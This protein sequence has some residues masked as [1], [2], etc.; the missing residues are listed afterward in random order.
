MENIR[1]E[2]PYSI[3]Y[4]YTVTDKADGQ[5]MLL[6][7][8]NTGETWMNKLHL[9]DS[10]LKILPVDI[11]VK[12]N[13]GLYIFNGE[14]ITSLDRNKYGIFDTYFIN[15]Q[16]YIHAPLLLDDDDNTRI[17]KAIDFI[18]NN[19]ENNDNSMEIMVKRFI[20]GNDNMDIWTAGR[21]IWNNK[22]TYH[23]DGLIY[24]PAYEP[25]GFDINNKDSD[26]RL[27]T[28]WTRNMKWKPEYENTIDCLIR[29]EKDIKARYNGREVLVDKIENKAELTSGGQHEIKQYKIGNIF[30]GGNNEIYTTRDGKKIYS[31]LKPLPFKPR[32]NNDIV[33]NKIYLPLI[34]DTHNG[35]WRIL[36]KDNKEVEDDTIVELIYDKTNEEERYQY[37]WSILRT[38]YDKTYLYK[39]GRYAQ[40]YL[41]NILQICLKADRP[42]ESM[43]TKLLKYIY[44]PDDKD[45]NIVNRFI[46]N[47]KYIMATYKS[48][49][50]IKVD[51]KFG[52]TMKVA[53]SI[54]NSIHNPITEKNILYGEDIPDEDIYYNKSEDNVRSYSVTTVLQKFHNYIKSE[55][56]LRNAIEY[57]KE[58][59]GYAHILDMTCG[60]GGDIEKWNLYGANRCLALDLYKSNIDNAKKRYDNFKQSNS[61]F[62]TIDFIE[63]DASKRYKTDTA[64]AIPSIYDRDN[65]NNLMK[66]VYNKQPFNVI[67]FMFSIHYFFENK[68]SFMNMIN[69]I[70]DH[71]AEGGL[72]IGTCFDGN[73]ILKEYINN[74]IELL[75][76]YINDDKVKLQD[77]IIYKD[78]RIIL[79]IKPTFIEKNINANWL[80]KTPPQ[81]PDDNDSI[82]LDIDVF[83]YTI[84]KTVKEYLVN[85]KYLEN[86]LKKYNIVRLTNNEISSMSLPNDKSIGSFEDVYEYMGKIRDKIVDDKLKKKINYILDSLSEEEFNISRLN[87]YFM[88]I[89][90]GRYVTDVIDKDLDELKEKYNKYIDDINKLDKVGNMKKYLDILGKLTTLVK[91]TTNTGTANMKKYNEDIIKPE[92][93]KLM[94]DYKILAKK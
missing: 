89:K 52:N 41:F 35:K 75:Q 16:S 42:D 30:N 44:M 64:K 63:G 3:K 6:F 76:N 43:I 79:K 33:T 56:L 28:T 48:D 25:V 71:L 17:S 23:L 7:C 51:I 61:Q 26:L 57:C 58:H 31:V 1:E 29:F 73:R 83:I 15:G 8:F 22:H 69:N 39:Q 21:E 13:N 68:V 45:K 72:L 32:I 54:W 70:N 90:R 37:N 53:N 55:I 50:D 10:N 2:N 74:F 14:Y 59:M 47:K 27:G 86:E 5:G 40:K 36:S 84:E 78:G 91:E 20:I 49:E 65:Y 60:Q 38:R 19:I 94:A 9:I 93:R 92:L 18:D 77:L 85:Y 46:A 66:N 11:N 82:G 62:V 12:S 4:N 24:T 34:C 67:P 87:G 88:F 80:K 81:L